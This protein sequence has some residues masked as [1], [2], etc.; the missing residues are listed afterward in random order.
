MLVY[1]WD[2]SVFACLPHGRSVGTECHQVAILA[3]ALVAT[4]AMTLLNLHVY[5]DTVV[6]VGG[7]ALPL[8]L[9][10]KYGIFDGCMDGFICVVF[11]GLALV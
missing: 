1:V 4:L 7:V 10:Q 3:K 8:T 2:D 11:L 6:L 9:D 5:L